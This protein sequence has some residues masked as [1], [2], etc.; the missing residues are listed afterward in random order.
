MP[1]RKVKFTIS[2]RGPTALFSSGIG[3]SALDHSTHNTTIGELAA[4]YGVS[5]RTLRFYEEKGFLMPMRV[6]TARYYSARD[7]VRLELILKGKRL[8]F[9]LDEI[10][11]LIAGQR[12][13]ESAAWSDIAATLDHDRIG[14]QLQALERQREEIDRAIDEL[15]V[16]LARKDDE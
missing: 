2:P 14:E 9:T 10:W 1:L 15:R 4:Y 6:G 13:E 16:A 8:G 12:G 11:T 5:L 7:R 3:Q